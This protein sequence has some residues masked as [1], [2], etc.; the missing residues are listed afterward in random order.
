MNRPKDAPPS[1]ELL[2][3]RMKCSPDLC[4]NAEEDAWRARECPPYH[5]G[6]SPILRIRYVGVWD[7]VGS[8]G[9]PDNLLIAGLFNQKHQFHD[10]CLSATTT[11]ARHAVAIDEDRKSFSPTLWLNV[12]TLNAELGFDGADPRAPYQ[13]KWFP[14]TH[15]SV[16]GG[17]DDRR[18]SDEA[19]D[20]VLSGATDMGLQLDTVDYS[21]VF[22]RRP[23]FT[24]P[25]DNMSKPPKFNPANFLMSRLPRKMRAPGPQRISDVSASAQQR[26]C[27][28]AE[29]LAEGKTYRPGTLARVA[30]DL[31]R[32]DIKRPLAPLAGGPVRKAAPRTGPHSPG[33]IF[34][35]V[36]RGDT[37]SSLALLQY[38]DAEQ[39]RAIFDA[40]RSTLTDPDRVYPGQKLWLPALP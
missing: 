23:D 40:N 21:V 33:N 22:T 19:L 37:L 3:F 36:Q 38:G 2:R 25:I 14:G 7:T 4:V 18:L 1:D 28:P 29:D 13:Q 8:L 27:T 12:E 9:V 17:G 34:H 5:A 24:A 6:S 31:D 30:G 10:Q 15:G 20:W 32:C 39:W 35:T 26:W 11:S 16:G